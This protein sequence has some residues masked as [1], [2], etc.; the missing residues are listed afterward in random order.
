MIRPDN[1]AA[2][3]AGGLVTL[4][5]LPPLSGSVLIVI[6]DIP[7]RSRI[8]LLLFLV[9]VIIDYPSSPPFINENFPFISLLSLRHSGSEV[10]T[11]DFLIN[12]FD[13]WL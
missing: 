5:K 13:C 10:T 9:L 7:Y 6:P 4:I 8:Q 1:L 2:H 12:E 11:I 3:V